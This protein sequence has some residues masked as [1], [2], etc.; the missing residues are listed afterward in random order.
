MAAT[1]PTKV[2]RARARRLPSRGQPGDAVARIAKAVVSLLASEGPGA[3]T[4]RR[5][6]DAAGVSLA[7]TTYYYASK[8]E[9][10]ADAQKRL[11]DDYVEAF[12]RAKRRHRAGEPVVRDLP[13][14]VAKLVKNATGRHG[15]DTLAWSEI[16]LNCARDPRGQALAQAWYD[17]LQAVWRELLVEF[18]AEQPNALVNPAIDTVVGLL[19]VAVSLQLTAEEV[20]DLLDGRRP[21]AAISARLLPA[22]APSSFDSDRPAGRSRATR[23]RIIDAAVTALETRDPAGLSF[24]TIAQRARLTNAAPAYHFPTLEALLDLAN[25]EVTRRMVGRSI[26]MMEPPPAEKVGLAFAADLLAAIHI[27]GVLECGAADLAGYSAWLNAARKP[28]HRA[29]VSSAFLQFEAAFAEYLSILSDGASGRHA[30]LLMAQFFGRSVRM[31]ATGARTVDL[32]GARR[33]FE[34]VIASIRAGTHPVLDA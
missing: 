9:M 31:L 5:V 6:A 4:H 12:E 10:I 21:L 13:E 3:V 8:F 22:R 11:L 28:A 18:G 26:A 15:R 17:R 2:E 29:G 20:D 14:L 32:A 16:M 23:G 25:E 33:D 27:R 7:S 1:K 24:T 30:L 34:G 19:F